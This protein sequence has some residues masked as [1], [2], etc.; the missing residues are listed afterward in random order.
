M[1]CV[2]FVFLIG[3]CPSACII[4]LQSKANI[5]H[6]PAWLTNQYS[7]LG[8]AYKPLQTFSPQPLG[9][10]NLLYNSKE[11][12]SFEADFLNFRFLLLNL[13]EQVENDRNL[14]REKKEDREKMLS[15]CKT[16][17]DWHI[18]NKNTQVTLN[19]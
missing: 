11:V 3:L 10:N 19:Y 2:L 6:Y 7:V 1:N 18:F 15:F 14:Q 9:N 17:G 13:S 16:T 5:T 12:F 4:F 8:N